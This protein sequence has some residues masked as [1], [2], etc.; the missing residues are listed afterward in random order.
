[1]WGRRLV[2]AALGDLGTVREARVVRHLLSGADVAGP[3]RIHDDAAHVD[4]Q[5]WGE[6]C[7]QLV[8]EELGG[9]PT[10]PWSNVTTASVAIPR[11]RNARCPRFGAPQSS[12]CWSFASTPKSSRVDVSP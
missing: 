7:L 1:M 2:R 5:Q 11:D 6:F 12:S 3:S 4:V 10:P 9:N 8:D